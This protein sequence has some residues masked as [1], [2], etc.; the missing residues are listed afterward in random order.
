MKKVTFIFVL[1]FFMIC[2]AQIASA[3][4]SIKEFGNKVDLIFEGKSFDFKNGNLR[5]VNGTL[6]VPIREFTSYI[7]VTLKKTS[8][9]TFAAI[10]HDTS[11][12]FTIDNKIAT[13]NKKNVTLPLAPTIVD[14]VTYMPLT[15]L[16][17]A[18]EYKVTYNRYIGKSMVVQNLSKIKPVVLTPE[19]YKFEY[20]DY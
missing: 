9:N 17:D 15:F 6:M 10:K 2:F 7:D 16:T 3:S 11:I 8:T 1:V 13:V 19:D 20:Y 18:F 4:T 14:S 12:E 5:D